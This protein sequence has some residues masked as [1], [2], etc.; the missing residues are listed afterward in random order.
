MQPKGKATA[1]P[2]NGRSKAGPF[3]NYGLPKLGDVAVKLTRTQTALR[4]G[5]LPL[6]AIAVSSQATVL[7]YH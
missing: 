4:E 3:G 1:H 6:A 2:K 7:P 5:L